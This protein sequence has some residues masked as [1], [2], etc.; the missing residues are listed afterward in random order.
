MRMGEG[1]FSQQWGGI[2]VFPSL[3]ICLFYF[4]AY[5][6]TA[7]KTENFLNLNASITLVIGHNTSNMRSCFKGISRLFKVSLLLSSKF[8]YFY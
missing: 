5:W 4:M 8:R 2:M 6:F 7:Y 1:C 3:P